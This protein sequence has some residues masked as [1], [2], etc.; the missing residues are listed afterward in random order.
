VTR[1]LYSGLVSLH[2]PAF[3]REFSGEMLWIFEETAAQGRCGASARL[4]A[5]AALSILRQWVIGCGTWKIAAAFVGG[6]L[7]LWLVFALLMLRPP[8]FHL[9]AD[10]MGE[11]AIFHR[12]AEARQ[13]KPACSS[14]VESENCI[15]ESLR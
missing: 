11:P 15:T 14:Y 4:F 13:E 8:V 5:D 9:A 6:L 12:E 10:S 1:A 3:R 2:P 7:H